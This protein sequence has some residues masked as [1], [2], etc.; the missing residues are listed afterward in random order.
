[1][2][3]GSRYYIL[4]KRLVIIGIMVLT[5]CFVIN[6]KMPIFG[7]TVVSK[8]FIEVPEVKSLDNRFESRKEDQWI[9]TLESK[10]VIFEV[11]VDESEYNVLNKG[12]SYINPWLLIKSYE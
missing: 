8:E 2:F 12:S 5:Y 9:I 10:G 7:G 3:F 1:M 4:E 11:E 6:F